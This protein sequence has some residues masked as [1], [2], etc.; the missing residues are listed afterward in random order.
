MSYYMGKPAA[1]P[2]LKTMLRSPLGARLYWPKTE[3]QVACF[4]YGT[5]TLWLQDQLQ[6]V[7][8]DV[9]ADVPL[10]QDW[11]YAADGYLWSVTNDQLHQYQLAWT[12]AGISATLIHSTP[13]DASFWRIL[14]SNN[15]SVYAQIH[16]VGD[17]CIG[18]KIE[19]VIKDGLNTVQIAWMVMDNELQPVSQ[20]SVNGLDD[21]I[22]YQYNLTSTIA[23]DGH[24]ALPAR[25]QVVID[26]NPIWQY[27][28]KVYAHAGDLA[29]ETDVT[30]YDP[31]L[32]AGSL[33]IG[34][35]CWDASS[36]SVYVVMFQP[37]VSATPHWKLLKV[38]AAGTT[39]IA[40]QETITDFIPN[41]LLYANGSV[42]TYST[43]IYGPTAGRGRL[44]RIGDTGTFEAIASLPDTDAWRH[45]I[46]YNAIRYGSNLMSMELG[47]LHVPSFQLLVDYT[48]GGTNI[49]HADR[50]FFRDE[51][52]AGLIG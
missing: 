32:I 49:E 43:L 15:G 16:Q 2:L 31:T 13:A 8:T 29:W 10:G 6:D 50:V 23:V 27:S 11:I 7:P 20:S 45:A 14:E 12:Y 17:R 26:E 34:S 46:W 39:E 25:R 52:V 30:S 38:N 44:Y 51:Y 5:T 24:I 37:Y 4:N 48:T 40:S 41:Q 35:Y 19:T 42:V 1:A 18:I 47:I 28:I 22:V 36:Q 33:A 3:A 9:A 21:N